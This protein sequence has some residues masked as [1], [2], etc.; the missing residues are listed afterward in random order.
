MPE[1]R[2]AGFN[3]CIGNEVYTNYGVRATITASY[4][5]VEGTDN[6]NNSWQQTTDVLP[7]VVGLNDMK[8]AAA[9]ENMPLLIGIH[10]IRLT[11]ILL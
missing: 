11:D 5:A 4:C 1:T 3:N 9:S 8:G 2:Y 10:G 6:Y 7:E